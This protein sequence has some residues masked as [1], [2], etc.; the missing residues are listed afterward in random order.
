MEF[1]V[2]HNRKNQKDDKF[3]AMF[4]HLH[5]ERNRPLDSIH[6]AIIQQNSTTI[7]TNDY[8]MLDPTRDED[9][10]PLRAQVCEAAI[11]QSTENGTNLI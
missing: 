2:M 1:M 9:A 5:N 10:K 11:Y 7:V 4:Y 6:A 8:Q 3:W